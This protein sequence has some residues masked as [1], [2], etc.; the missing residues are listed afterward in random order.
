MHGPTPKNSPGTYHAERTACCVQIPTGVFVSASFIS[1][2]FWEYVLRINCL[3]TG[4]KRQVVF[5]RSEIAT[6][7]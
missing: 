4:K 1:R 7:V 3:S 5:F 6:Y 2:Y